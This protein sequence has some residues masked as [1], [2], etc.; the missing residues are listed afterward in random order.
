MDND[1][2]L[3]VQIISPEKILF[4]GHVRVIRFPGL[5]SP[6][7]VFRNHAPLISVLTQGVIT[8]VGEV[9]HATKGRIPIKDG[10]VQIN[11]NTVYA[12]VTPE[13]AL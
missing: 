10:F 8:F 3:Y 7:A 2:P 13:D 4:E 6:F 12:C 5:R 9:D 1:F 11:N